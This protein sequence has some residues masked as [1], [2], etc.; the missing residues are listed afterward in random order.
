[1]VKPANKGHPKV[2]TAQSWSLKKSGLYLE[3]ILWRVTE[4]WP[5]FTGWSLFRDGLLHRFDCIISMWKLSFF[6]TE[7]N[8]IQYL[9]A[10]ALYNKYITVES[11]GLH[12]LWEHLWVQSKWIW[13]V[14]H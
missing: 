2:K 7:R 12:V 11:K 9:T 6:Y 13:F 10:V 8:I 4:V 14:Q 1:M 5:L 3:V